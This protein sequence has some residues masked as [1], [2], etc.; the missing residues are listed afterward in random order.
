MKHLDMTEHEEL[1][2]PKKEVQDFVKVMK[3]VVKSAEK[4]REFP[5]LPSIDQLAVSSVRL[6]PLA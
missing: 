4:V 3:G 1:R 2:K 6:G 5:A